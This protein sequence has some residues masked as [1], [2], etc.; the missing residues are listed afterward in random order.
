MKVIVFKRVDGQAYI[1]S[2]SNYKYLNMNDIAD[3]YLCLKK[4]VEHLGNEL[5][6]SLIV[7]IRSCVIWEM[8]HDYQLGI[9]SYLIIVNL[10]ALT[11]TFFGM[12]TL[13]LYPIITHPFIGIVYENSKKEMRVMNID[14]LQKFCDATLEKVLK[15]VKEIY[16]KAR[17]GFKDPPLNEADKEIMVVL[18]EEIQECLKY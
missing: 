7:Y 6:K 2:E 18:E 11:L 4:E 1:F 8:V 9:E 15:N 12:E 13:S 3:M 14:K 5:R 16:V 10:T 17:H